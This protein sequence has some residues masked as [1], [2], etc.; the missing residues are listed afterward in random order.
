MP[1]LL[2]DENFNGGIIQGLLPPLP[3]FDIISVHDAGLAAA[4]DPTILEW[5]AE[6]NRIV[7]THDRTTMSKYANERVVR[8]QAMPGV[9]IINVHYPIGLAIEQIRLVIACSQSDE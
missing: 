4:A 1:R 5:A 2:A 7:L 3:D 9:L 8:A 6:Q